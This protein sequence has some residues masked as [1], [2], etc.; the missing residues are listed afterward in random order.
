MTVTPG[1]LNPAMTSPS[2]DTLAELAATQHGIFAVSH[3]VDLEYSSDARHGRLSAGRWDLLYDGVY[4]MGGAPRTWRGDLLAGCW[5]AGTRALASCRSAAEL[6][7]LPSGRTDMIEIT[8]PRW[9][10]T[11]HGELV[12]HES[13]AIDD[14]DHAE[15]DGIPCTSVARTLFDLARTLS[16]AM[17]DANIDNA[18]RREL[19]TLDELRTTSARLATKGRPGGRR[20]R[21]VIEARSQG[22][23]LP[24]SVPERLLAD[25]LVR[26]G[27]PAPQHQ[28]V[29]RDAAGGF[30]ARVD[31]AY[32]EWAV[33]IEYDSVEHHTGTPAHIRDSARRNA[34][35]D[36]GYAVLT[37]TSADLKDRA[38]RIAKSI[39]Q[40]RSH[41]A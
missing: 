21:Q 35:G 24:E 9:N 19:V 4:R 14:E 22:S 5:A 29:I 8:C 12:V 27:L 32:P 13:M 34:I 30:V 41:A 28:F 17:L 2:D 11:R 38:A 33:V 15:V 6:W 37:A 25:M 23:A 7:G 20:F 10:R 1:L 40:R 39:R 26:Q 36:L 18:I 31:L 3:L 16:P